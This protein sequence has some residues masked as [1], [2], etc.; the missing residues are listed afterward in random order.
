MYN[1]QPL[2]VKYTH[3]TDFKIDLQ[4]NY[5]NKN[6]FIF[7]TEISGRYIYIYCVIKAVA[8]LASKLINPYI[9]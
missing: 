4:N 5:E 3:G 6:I 8:S 7:Y 9:I 2:T 1:V